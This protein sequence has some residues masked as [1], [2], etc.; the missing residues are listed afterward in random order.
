MLVADDCRTIQ[1]FFR[2]AVAKS[3]HAVELIATEDGLECAALLEGGAFDLAFVDVNMPGM[4]GMEALGAARL[5]GIKTCVTIMS[6][7]SSAPW[8][9]IARQLN[10]YEYLVKPF[11][12]Q[13]VEVAQVAGIGELVEVDHRL[14]LRQQ[15]LQHEIGADE[16]GPSRCNQPHLPSGLGNLPAPGHYHPFAAGETSSR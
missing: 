15:P 5:K 9:K 8:T 10:A 1:A 2:S 4:S 6:S 12:A 7:K 3:S 13:D 11:T 14:V 16:P